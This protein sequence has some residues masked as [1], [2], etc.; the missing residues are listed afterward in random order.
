MGAGTGAAAARFLPDRVIGTQLM[1]EL[2]RRRRVDSSSSRHA[3]A[4][5]HTRFRH[6]RQLPLS[7]DELH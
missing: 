6:G 1:V 3:G 4:V 7:R 2:Q 5:V